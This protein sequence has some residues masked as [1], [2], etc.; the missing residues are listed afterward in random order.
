[1]KSI[2][3]FLMARLVNGLMC[4]SFNCVASIYLIEVSPKHLKGSIGTLYHIALEIG[5]VCTSVFGLPSW[6]GTSEL[7]IYLYAISMIPFF[8]NAVCL[9][10]C[11]ETPK[12]VFTYKN[13]IEE[14]QKS[15]RFLVSHQD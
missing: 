6:L 7:W 13:N 10:F 9:P 3:P 8:I 15:T 12:Y 4:G 2:W 1:M 11:V 14:V 5:I